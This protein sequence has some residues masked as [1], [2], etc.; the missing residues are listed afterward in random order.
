MWCKENFAFVNAIDVWTV[1]RGG[2]GDILRRIVE[3]HM[4]CVCS[5]LSCSGQHV[6][7]FMHELLEEAVELPQ[8][9]R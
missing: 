7:S 8:Q 1:H 6:T 4:L 3:A 9:T 2:G 5:T